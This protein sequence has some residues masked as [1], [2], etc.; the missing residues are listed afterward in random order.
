MSS[1]YE[2]DA[3]ATLASINFEEEPRGLAELVVGQENGNQKSAIAIAFLTKIE[4]CSLT[5]FRYGE[6]KMLFKYSKEG[7]TYGSLFAATPTMLL[8]AD[9]SLYKRV[10]SKIRFM[11]TNSTR[12]KVLLK[13]I[14]T[15]SQSYARSIEAIATIKRGGKTLVLVSEENKVITYDYETG[16]QLAGMAYSVHSFSIIDN[17][18]PKSLQ[19][20]YY[21]QQMFYKIHE[22]LSCLYLTLNNDLNEVGLDAK[23]RQTLCVD[24]RGNVFITLTTVGYLIV[25]PDP[26]TSAVTVFR[27]YIN[28]HIFRPSLLSCNPVMAQLAIV[29]DIMRE[30]PIRVY[31]LTYPE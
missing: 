29:D 28:A 14:T 12:P 23:P 5:D 9:D 8:F 13:T 10:P 1:G 6:Y 4:L 11:Q 19:F 25:T 31:T 24:H 21:L 16:Q 20:G 18:L 7:Q 26:T 17:L 15:K 2:K 30:W 3:P 22:T 27:N